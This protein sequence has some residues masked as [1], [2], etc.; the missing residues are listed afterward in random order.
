MG[1]SSSARLQQ[2]GRSQQSTR[3]RSQHLSRHLTQ[4]FRRR[5]LACKINAA[6]LPR[7]M[8]SIVM[9]ARPLSP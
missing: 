4:F 2:D 3:D 8:E 7:T 6:T 9:N 5:E 1:R